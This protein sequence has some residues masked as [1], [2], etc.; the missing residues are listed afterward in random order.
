[1]QLNMHFPALVFRHEQDASPPKALE[2]THDL[3][4]LKCPW[5][6][7]GPVQENSQAMMSLNGQY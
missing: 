2:H 5:Q 3:A 6:E 4:Q 1:M 7:T